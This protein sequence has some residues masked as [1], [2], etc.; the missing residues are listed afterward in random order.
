MAKKK[1]RVKKTKKATKAV[2]KQVKKEKQ[3][4]FM[5]HIS[6]PKMLRKDVLEAL[7]E[8]IIFLQGYETIKKLQQEKVALFQQ[9]KNDIKE[10]S[11]LIDNKLKKYLPRGKLLEQGLKEKKEQPMPTPS[12]PQ[13]AS[14]EVNL[15][16]E[17]V[18]SKST[19]VKPAQQLPKIEEN[20]LDDLERQL[21]EIENQLRSV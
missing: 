16:Y 4:Q 12:I 20:N 5:V 1:K 18:E 8:S 3:P 2:K 19:Q 14:T 15:P 21:Q 11:N 7:R 10:L 13:P 6:D 17:P 9:I